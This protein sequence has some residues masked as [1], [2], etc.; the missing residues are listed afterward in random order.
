M[1]QTAIKQA[2]S[3][4]PEVLNGTVPR[5]LTSNLGTFWCSIIIGKNIWKKFCTV[6]TLLSFFLLADCFRG[7]HYWRRRKDIARTNSQKLFL[8]LEAAKETRLEWALVLMYSK[9]I[10]YLLNHTV[11]QCG[12]NGFNFD[13]MIFIACS[14]VHSWREEHWIPKG[15]GAWKTTQHILE[16]MTKSLWIWEKKHVMKSPR[17]DLLGTHAVTVFGM[18]CEQHIGAPEHSP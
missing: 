17:K 14:S 7:L 4:V 16:K 13:N 6:P 10:Q 5:W 18:A 12:E 1:F 11:R 15:R 9:R 8:I 3:L 2:V